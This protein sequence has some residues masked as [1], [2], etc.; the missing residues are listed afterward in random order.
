MLP[1]AP[2]TL[3]FAG[4][5]RGA[6][7]TRPPLQEL[8]VASD[9]IAQLHTVGGLPEWEVYVALHM[10]TFPHPDQQRARS[11]AVQELLLRNA[12]HWDAGRRDLLRRWG[13]PRQ[14][15]AHALAVFAKSTGDPA[16]AGL[17]RTVLAAALPGPRRGGCRWRDPERKFW[18]RRRID[19]TAF[20][21][22]R[23][24]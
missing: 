10:P 18:E 23:R 22:R 20:V 8:M 1:A 2:P 9:L 3:E 13:V 16:G 24:V 19:V 17:D 5:P 6:H 15:V 7:L 4:K 14:W 21:A 12:P 11:R